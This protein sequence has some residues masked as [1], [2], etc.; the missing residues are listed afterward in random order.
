MSH[1][2]AAGLRI[3]FLKMHGAANDFVVIDHRGIA[4]PEPPDAWIARICDR[5]RGVGADGVILL[6]R[7]ATCDFAMRYFNRDGGAADFC[8]NG[9]RCA[10]RRGL[11]L[12]LGSGGR[13]R[14]RTAVGVLDAEP[15]AGGG[16]ALHFGRVER[17]GPE[18]T[19]QVEGRTVR[20]RFV[21]AGVPHLVVPVERLSQVPLAE[22]AP[23]L[24]RHPRWGA[25]GANVDFVERIAPGRIAMR[26]YERGVEAETLACGSGAMASALWA[27]AHGDASPMVVRTWGGDDLEVRFEPDGEAWDV[28]LVG[29]AT[30][31]FE[32]V[33]TE[34]GE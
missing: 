31:A 2:S 16:I 12:G 26:T 29:P 34:G 32:G 27:A 6:E 30:V 1:P 33:W 22:W 14:F 15:T 3:A 23:P 13:I 21:R 9:A 5:R 19:L 24:R 28:T 11:D 18:E 17:A 7:D 8:G 10:A 25:E 4:L 20:G